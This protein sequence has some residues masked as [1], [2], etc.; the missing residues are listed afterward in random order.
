M[1][2]LKIVAAVSLGMTLGIMFTRVVDAIED[3]YKMK[4]MLNGAIE[5]AQN[6]ENKKKTQ[7]K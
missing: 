3:H 4:L 5:H 7:K 1:I 2:E 6:E